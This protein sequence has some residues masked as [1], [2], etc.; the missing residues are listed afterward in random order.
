MSNCEGA[1]A[2]TSNLRE[3]DSSFGKALPGY[4]AISS[5]MKLFNPVLTCTGSSVCVCE[6]C[7][8]V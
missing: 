2:K 3:N 8:V 5:A 7:W 1:H 6:M 4:H